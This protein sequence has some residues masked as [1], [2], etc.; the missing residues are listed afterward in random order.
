MNDGI[1]DDNLKAW[2]AEIDG[3]QKGIVRWLKQHPNFCKYVMAS[4]GYTNRR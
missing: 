2:R 4:Y 3:V 1:T